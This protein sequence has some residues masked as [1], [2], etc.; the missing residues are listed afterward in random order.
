MRS[1]PIKAFFPREL[2]ANAA[3]AV[4]RRRFEGLT[5]PAVSLPWEAKVRIPPDQSARTLTIANP[6][7]GMSKADLMQRLGTIA[8]FGTLALRRRPR[9]WRR[10]SSG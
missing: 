4:D 3:D 1:I 8:R 9:T 10:R 5:A 6:G 7:I 2:V